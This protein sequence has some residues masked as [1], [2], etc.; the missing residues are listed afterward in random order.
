MT[1]D[2][3]NGSI[4]VSETA[5]VESTAVLIGPC[6]IGHNAYVGHN[7]VIGAP[8]QYTGYYPFPITGKKAGAGVQVSD[9]ACVRELVQ[10]NQGIQIP[11]TVGRDSLVMASVH[12]GHDT[13]IG[14]D[15]II[16]P[17]ST[18][19][20]HTTIDD[21]VTMGQ[22]C[23][24]HPWTIVGRAAM[25]GLNTGLIADVMP[26]QK[27][28]GTPARVIGFNAGPNGVREDWS[29]ESLD[30][31]D[32]TQYRLLLTERKNLMKELKGD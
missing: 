13:T 10:M 28:A 3:T 31:L 9:G 6:H 30:E 27:V 16:A 12:I 32:W 25:V 29:S 7:A 15:C 4:W 1:R 8:A 23:V 19:G 5:I 17:L 18:F 22:G 2:D 24:T 14:D 20:G 21:M 11:T 26:Y